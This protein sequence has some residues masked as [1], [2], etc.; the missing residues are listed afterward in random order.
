MELDKIIPADGP[1][2]N[3]VEKYINKYQSEVIVIKCGGSVL[4]DK[5]LFNQFIEDISVINKIGL[6]AIVVHGG[7]KNIKKKLDEKNIE[8]RFINGLRI[9]DE[10]T[11]RYIE[12]ASSIYLIV[13]SSEILSPLINLVSIFFSSNFF[14]IFLHPPWTTIAD[15]PIL[16]I[17]EISSMN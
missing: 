14:L 6:S 9:S 15:K 1:N 11:I 13:F 4:L 16:F 10:K 12:E 5:K 3:E 2:I 7:C 17:T 8:T